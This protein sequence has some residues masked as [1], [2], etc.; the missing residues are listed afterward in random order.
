MLISV[1]LAD[2]LGTGDPATGD[3]LVLYPII[4]AVIDCLL[5]WALMGGVGDCATLCSR[6]ELAARAMRLRAA[7]VPLAAA[8]AVLL[9]IA[10][11]IGRLEGRGLVVVPA[12]AC[13]V[14][15]VVWLGTAL[16]LLYRV[17]SAVAAQTDRRPQEARPWQ[18]SLR[19]LM[20]APV[21]LWL[22]LLACFPKLVTGDFCRVRIDQLSVDKKWQVSYAYSTRT[23]S[24]TH[25]KSATLPR[26]GSGSGYCTGFPAW[27]SH[28]GSSGYFNLFAD[29]RT[30]TADEIRGRLLVEQG[31]TYRVVPGKP[32]YFYDFVGRDGT[33][34]CEYLE[35]T[36]G[37][38]LGL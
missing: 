22:L 5:V 10:P 12:A 29:G 24:G 33:R 31:K 19:T 35:V 3:D 8:T 20:L 32:L 26:G 23:S 7:Y 17:R 1:W 30:L 14:A 15:F 11:E 37:S 25:E 13:L 21:A 6:P 18:Y 36:P 9:L 28:G 38:R 16:H 2:F 34:Y 4:R 27:P